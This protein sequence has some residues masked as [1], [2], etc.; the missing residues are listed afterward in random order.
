[1]P[2]ERAKLQEAMLDTDPENQYFVDARTGRVLRVT[3]KDPAGLARFKTDLAA[4]PKRFVQVARPTGRE[5]FA[6]LQAFVASVADPT[7]RTRLQGALAS[8]SPY[9]ELN[10]ALEG[11]FKEKRQ[12]EAFRRQQVDKRMADFLKLT[13]LA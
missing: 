3:L 10:L 8:P 13:G 2:V 7:L 6:E 5:R 11:R 9:R 4:D 12:W 1:M